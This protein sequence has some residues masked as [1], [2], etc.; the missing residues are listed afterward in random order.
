MQEV[1]KELHDEKMSSLKELI[2]LK[3]EKLEVEKYK[4]ENEVM[5]MS[6]NELSE[7]QEN[8][9]NFVELKSW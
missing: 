7:E 1:R 3:K 2:R 9:L 4:L 8:L 5:L 6:T